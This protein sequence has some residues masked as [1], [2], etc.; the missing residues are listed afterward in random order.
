MGNNSDH[1]STTKRHDHGEPISG[2]TIIPCRDP[3]VGIRHT[4]D[5]VTRWRCS[6][7][8]HQQNT[9]AKTMV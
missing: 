1:I 9:T 5:L 6:S 7:S 2:P 3:V 8:C 4:F